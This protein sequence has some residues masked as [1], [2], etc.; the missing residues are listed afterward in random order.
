MVKVWKSNILEIEPYKLKS[1][2]L[3]LKNV[4][5]VPML[6]INVLSVKN[7]CKDNHSWFIYD[8]IQFFVQDKAT[9]A[10]LHQGK[11]SNDEFS[12]FLCI[13]FLHY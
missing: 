6:T 11:S 10:I 12:G 8:D 4:L 1:Q 5:H 2:V 7:L 3:Y 13:Y 9:G